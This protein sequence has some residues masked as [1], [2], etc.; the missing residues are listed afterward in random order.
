TGNSMRLRIITATRSPGATPASS[1]RAANPFARRSRSTNDQRS[2]PARSASLLPNRSAAA[3]RPECINVTVT[4]G[5]SHPSVRRL[6][7]AG[8]CTNV[9]T[10]CHRLSGSGGVEGERAAVSTTKIDGEIRYDPY[11]PAL[12]VD[13]FPVFRRMREETPLYYNE[14]YDFFALSRFDDV[15]AAFKDHQTFSSAKS[16]ILELIKTPMELPSGV[17][18][19][20]DPPLHS[21]H[22][23]ILSRVFTPRKMLA[24]EP[25]IREYCARVL[26]PLVG[27]D[28]FDFMR[29]LRDIITLLVLGMLLGI[30][31]ADQDEVRKR[32]DDRLRHEAGMPR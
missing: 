14:E 19:F 18:I 7:S 30:P 6:L 5:S 25:Q 20:E 32:G 9:G 22:R 10:A 26:D 1:S 15:E 23:G 12:Q 13:P 31:E 11:D 29:H 2:T 21:A 27:R 28:C 3:S 24:L 17:F 4:R 8:D 16:D